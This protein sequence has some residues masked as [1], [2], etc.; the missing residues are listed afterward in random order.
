MKIMYTRE[1]MCQKG[2]H[3]VLPLGICL[4]GGISNDFFFYP[5]DF[6]VPLTFFVNHVIL[7]KIA[8]H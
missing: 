5:S 1:C 3:R 7:I 6:S 2:G 8:S 4:G